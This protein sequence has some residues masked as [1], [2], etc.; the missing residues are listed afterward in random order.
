MA[1]QLA[2]SVPVPKERLQYFDYPANR[3]SALTIVGW[4]AT[5]QNVSETQSGWLVEMRIQPEF[6][7]STAFTADYYTE[8]F[9]YRNRQ[10]QFLRGRGAPGG[11]GMIIID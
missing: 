3:D 6:R 5:I 9:H 8:Y 7:H 2:V 4:N 1:E 11:H 10:F